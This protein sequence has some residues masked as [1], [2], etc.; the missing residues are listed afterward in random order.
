MI[1]R[2]NPVSDLLMIS[3]LNTGTN[4]KPERV[5]IYDATGR[6]VYSKVVKGLDTDGRIEVPVS[7][8]A[9]G[10]YHVVVITAPRERYV[11][12]FVVAH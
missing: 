6:L 2:P 8:L 1:T 12:P 7:E 10:A 5:E 11:Q 3:L 9:N 4:S